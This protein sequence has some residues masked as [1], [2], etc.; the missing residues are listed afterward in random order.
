MKTIILALS[1]LAILI[2]FSSCRQQDEDTAITNELPNKKE[3]QH[4]LSKPA[5]S[6]TVYLENE[7]TEGEPPPKDGQQWKTGN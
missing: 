1:I 7:T 4:F 6:T 3:E 2:S 5:D